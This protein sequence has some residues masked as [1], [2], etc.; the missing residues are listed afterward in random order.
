MVTGEAV[1]DMMHG[2]MRTMD[3]SFHTKTVIRTGCHVS[4]AFD[5]SQWISTV[6]GMRLQGSA[7]MDAIRRRLKVNGK[8]HQAL[9]ANSA[10]QQ[11]LRTNGINPRFQ[12]QFRLFE[13]QTCTRKPIF[14]TAL[15]V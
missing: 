11:P 14:L 3:A 6:N 7:A 13:L 15:N 10:V 9:G 1:P 4:V 8:R 2:G 12:K 5:R